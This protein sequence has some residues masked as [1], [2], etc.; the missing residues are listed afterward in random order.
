MPTPVDAH[1]PEDL[2]D[3]ELTPRGDVHPSPVLWRNHIF[4]QILPDRFSD[5]REHERPLFD[6]HNPE[7]FRAPDKAAWMRAGLGFTGGSLR[8]VL[9]K[10]DY[11]QGLGVTGL[12][13][14]PAFKQRADL[15]TYHGYA[16][17]N[18]LDIDPRL[19]TRQDLRDL[20]DAA[21]ARGM[22]VLLDIVIDHTGNN[23]F[24][25]PDLTGR[26]EDSLPYRYDPPYSVA[27]WRSGDGQCV[28]HI[29]SLEDGCWPRQFQRLEAYNRRGAIVNWWNP[30][31]LDP[32]AEFRRGD[33]FD[34]KKLNG[35][36]DESLEAVIR[37]YQYWIAIS[38]C[39]GF[40]ID[41]AKHIA[42]QTCQ[43]FSRA[44]TQY[45]LSIGKENFLLVGEITDN[46]IA[47]NYLA[48][49][50]S[51]FERAL[52]AVLDINGS[53]ILLAGAARGTIDPRQFFARF[54][55]NSDL[56]RYVQTG[57]IHVSILDDHDM[58]C[59]SYKERFAANN[60]TPHRDWQVANAVAIQLLTPGI[61][62]LYYGTEQAFDGNEGYH[63]YS[64]EP[65]RFG[66][67]RYIREGMF[68]GPFG[69]FGTS[70]CHFFD[71]SHPTY[72]RIGAIARLRQRDDVI[73]R[74]L[75]LGVCYPR[76]TAF[77]GYPFGLPGAGELFAWSRVLADHEV[78]VVI[79]THGTEPRGADVTVDHSLHRHGTLTV[80]YRADWSDAQLA[81]TADPLTTT[82]E[83][84]PL[85]RQS[86]GRLT[87][88]L[89]LP[90]AG[91]VIL[92]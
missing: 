63:D 33:F 58:S 57:R 70:G 80:L 40:R 86:D 54:Q 83:R 5:G 73:G 77:S 32:N 18:F 50:G 59:K 44:I 24:Y 30:D 82:A 67:D 26:T 81:D 46:L 92:A 27:G 43:R 36:D 60:S 48:L 72:L 62:C 56:S 39:D 31:P 23:W 8:G 25:G 85:Q 61:P 88:R 55:L 21:H 71:T 76:E 90:A 68:G 52:T 16:I 66:E 42:K 15:S 22:V 91:M 41:A 75:R 7:Q 14:N 10:L 29:D 45:A 38:D 12:W 9:S 84:L 65:Q 13:L 49:F 11:L 35:F 47:E 20:V 4:Y 28:D 89:D 17:Q 37:C 64:I 1:A 51:V 34:L 19:G 53:P 3:L 6:R 87:V 2:I 69:A 78:L 79:N 74:T